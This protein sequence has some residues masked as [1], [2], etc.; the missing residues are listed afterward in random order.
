MFTRIRVEKV[1]GRLWDGEGDA[2][3]M[4][5][6]WEG[7]S[8]DQQLHGGRVAGELINGQDPPRTTTTKSWHHQ[9]R[10]ITQQQIILQKQS[11]QLIQ[12]KSTFF[13]IS[14]RKDFRLF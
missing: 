3:K 10:T 7:D 13:K 11:L 4:L 14:S 9:P 12:K 1:L 2:I 6:S 8:V 5:Q